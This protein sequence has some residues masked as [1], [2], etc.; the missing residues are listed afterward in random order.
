MYCALMEELMAILSTWFSQIGA[1]TPLNFPNRWPGQTFEFWVCR[2]VV[3]SLCVVRP[4]LASMKSFAYMQG[5]RLPFAI[6]ICHR[7]H[8][9]QSHFLAGREPQV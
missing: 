6:A 9:R 4:W 1:K 7:H 2:F 5:R 8:L 3:S